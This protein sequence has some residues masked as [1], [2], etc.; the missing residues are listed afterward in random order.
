VTL[1]AVQ[2]S[3]RPHGDDAEDSN[4]DYGHVHNDEVEHLFWFL[5]VHTRALGLRSQNLL[6]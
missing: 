3:F 6:P 5:P 2:L 4:D 1:L